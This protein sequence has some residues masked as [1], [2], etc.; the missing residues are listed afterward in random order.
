MPNKTATFLTN[1]TY[2]GPSGNTVTEPQSSVAAPYQSMHSGTL[3]VPPSTAPATAIPIPTGS[4]GTEITAVRIV[5]N[6]SLDIG[7]RLNGAVTD[8]YQVPP[9]GEFQYVTPVAATYLPLTAVSIATTAE[10][11]EI[12]ESVAY[13]VFGDPSAIA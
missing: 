6:L 3:D 8:E 1:F 4:I 11:V 7:I 9:G 13:W 2:T 5:N 10:Q 12:D